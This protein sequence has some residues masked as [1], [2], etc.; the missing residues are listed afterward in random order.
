MAFFFWSAILPN[1]VFELD[2]EKDAIPEHGFPGDAAGYSLQRNATT[3][4][5]TSASFGKRAACT[6]ERAGGAA[7]K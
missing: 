5:S 6:V 2:L 7:V 3:S 1:G 4:I